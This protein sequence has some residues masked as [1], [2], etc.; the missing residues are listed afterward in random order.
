MPSVTQQTSR[1]L[2]EAKVTHAAA[3]SACAGIADEGERNDC[4][5][6]VITMANVEIAGAYIDRCSDEIE[7]AFLD[8]AL[9]KGDLEK[10][11]LDDDDTV[12]PYEFLSYMLVTLGKVGL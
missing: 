7:D 4:V 11:D 2:G 3:Q 6:D 5:A 8:R 9:E 1:R 10:M 12:K